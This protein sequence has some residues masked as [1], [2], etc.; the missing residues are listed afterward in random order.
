MQDGARA[1]RAS[2]TEHKSTALNLRLL[3]QIIHLDVK[4]ANVLLDGDV[5]GDLEP[6]LS[7]FGSAK[8][9][10]LGVAGLKTTAGTPAFRAPEAWPQ[11]PAREVR[12]SA[13]LFSFAALLVC[14]A[15]QHICPYEGH[16]S[17]KELAAGVLDGDARAPSLPCDEHPWRSIVTSCTNLDAAERMLASEAQKE[18]DVAAATV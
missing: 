8:M 18:I 5:D 7:D 15:R 14:M 10:E 2:R 17:Y 6:K 9:L 1:K 16:V 11:E 12:T 4:P 3:S 13:D